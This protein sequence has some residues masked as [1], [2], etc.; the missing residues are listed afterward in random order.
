MR[1]MR[2]QK[3]QAVVEMA[4]FGSLILLLFATLLSYLQRANEQQYVQMEAFR[5]ALAKGN[6]FQGASSEGAGA[7]VQL[8]SIQNRRLSDISE[9]FR[10]GSPQTLSASSSV[11]WAVPKVGS[12]PDNAIV[13]KVNDDEKEII[14]DPEVKVENIDSSQKTSFEESNLKQETPSAITNTRTSKLKDTVTTKFLDKEGKT[15][16]EI[17]QGIYRDEKGQYRYSESQVDKEITRGKSW[18]TDF[19]DD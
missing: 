19:D 11:F 8:T 3:A 15:I 12:K 5:R 1:V 13:F 2:N 4:L 7:S 14:N 10:K 6:T 17:T 18:R 9:S 16:W